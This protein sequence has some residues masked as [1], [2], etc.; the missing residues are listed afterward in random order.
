MKLTKKIQYKLA[1]EHIVH[2]FT[3]FRDMYDAYVQFNTK[4]EIY[5]KIPKNSF[6]MLVDQIKYKYDEIF[7]KYDLRPDSIVEYEFTYIDYLKKLE[8]KWNYEYRLPYTKFKITNG[9]KQ[10]MYVR[11]KTLNPNMYQLNELFKALHFIPDTM[12]EISNDYIKAINT[13]IK[14]IFEQINL[15]DGEI[16]LRLPVV[17]TYINKKTSFLIT[18]TAD[19]VKIIPNGSY[20][21][22]KT[23]K[24]VFGEHSLI[25]DFK[26]HVGKNTWNY[27]LEC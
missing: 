25:N 4:Q 9:F 19:G 24:K 20:E 6:D 22:E 15:N 16:L 11:F 8:D 17:Q 10:K 26:Y 1:L 21:S 27:P 13:K 12:L 14:Q 3:S 18:G 5:K 2:E 23:F 7:L